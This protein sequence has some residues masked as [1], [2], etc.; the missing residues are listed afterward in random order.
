MKK[1]KKLIPAFCMLLVSAI[2]LGSSTFAWFSMN[3]K[4]TAS[5]MQV[6]AKT[7]TTF[8]LINNDG[9]TGNQMTAQDT[10]IVAKKPEGD[11]ATTL[12]PAAFFKTV[13]ATTTMGKKDGT[14]A[15]KLIEDGGLTAGTDV[16]VT[17][18]NGNRD[19]ANN[20]VANV[21]KLDPSETNFTN[22]TAEYKVW[23]T[24]LKGTAA[25][26]QYVKI[27]LVADTEVGAAKAVA[28]IGNE[29]IDLSNGA[30]AKFT[31]DKISLS[32]STAVQVSVFVYIDGN[33]A[34]VKSAT[35]V[36]TITGLFALDFTI[37]ETK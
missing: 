18:N 21:V 15:F 12:Y 14:N 2:M 24:L 10:T 31:A 28:K 7:N 6:N 36:T 20:K 32:D 27:S 26:Q 29:W 9:K 16:W 34:N 37:V 33:N 1:F 13:D 8:L 11:G 22:Y 35:D 4:V 3:T 19:D 23:L 17:A 25:T 5:N 30:E